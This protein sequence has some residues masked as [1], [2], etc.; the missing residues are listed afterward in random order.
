MN[1]KRQIHDGIVGAIITAG[2]A[3]GY[4]VSPMWLI[5]PGVIGLTLIQSAF[6]GFCPVYYTL[7]RLNVSEG[8]G[9]TVAHSA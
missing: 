4:W 7:D 2:V 1:K 5:L 9:D 3:L 6:T 8:E